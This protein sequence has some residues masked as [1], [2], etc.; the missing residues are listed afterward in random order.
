MIKLHVVYGDTHLDEYGSE[1]TLF[2][3][4]TSNELAM[5]A[6]KEAED[7]YY[8]KC[9]NDKYTIRPNFT[10]EKVRFHTKEIS[11]NQAIDEY[12]GGYAE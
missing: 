3:V 2:G 11:M 4:F 1:I 10:Q 6:Q 9:K 7:R 5:T 8:E 12:L